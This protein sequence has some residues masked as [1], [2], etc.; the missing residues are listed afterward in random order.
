MSRLISGM[1]LTVFFMG[2]M[3]VMLLEAQ[4]SDYLLQPE[5]I[6]Y[7]EVYEQPDLT[8]RARITSKGEIFL[9]LLGKIETAGLTASELKDKIQELLEKDYLVNPQ[10][11]VFI[12]EYHVRQISVLGAVN[13]PG[14]Y[15]MHTE[16]KTTLLEA[17]AMAGGFTDEADIDD[18]RIIRS[19]HEESQVTRVRV[20]DITKRGEKDKD[21]ALE[22]GDVIFVNSQ[23]EVFTKKYHTKQISV[24]GAVNKSGKYDM[25]T[26]RETTL[27]EAIAMAG[28]FSDVAAENDTRIIR[29]QGDEKRTIRV[30]I[31]DITK[32]GKKDVALEPG[33]I[34]F[35]PES[36]F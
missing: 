27:L 14:K 36:F 17:I 9:P 32:K 30:R 13:D 7:I 18:T 28:G 6:L 25:N 8:T 26:E 35:V 19:G 29:Q 11:H 4:E 3:A 33:D 22:P 10:I 1:M 21:V 15:D 20:T 34:I 16:K 31:T 23:V 12:E 24:L 2:F 5:D